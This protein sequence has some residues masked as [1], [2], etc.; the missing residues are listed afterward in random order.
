MAKTQHQRWPTKALWALEQSKE[1]ASESSDELTQ[2]MTKLDKANLLLRSNPEAA[3][4]LIAHAQ[5]S[6]AEA[7]SNQERIGRVLTEAEIGREPPERG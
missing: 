5:R 3:E 2:A 7:K 4:L 1:L 6:V